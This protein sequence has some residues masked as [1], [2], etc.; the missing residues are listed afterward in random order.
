M[1]KSRNFYETAFD[2]KFIGYRPSGL[3]LDLSDGVNNITLLQQPAD[4][5]RPRLEEGN[6]YIHFG[7]IVDD[8]EECWQRCREWG[9]EIS[10]GDVKHRTEIEQDERPERSFKVLDPDGNIID[11]TANKEEWRGIAVS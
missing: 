11:V 6:E 7:V 8:L 4:M 9:T 2:W 10:K 3:G 1:E 5:Q